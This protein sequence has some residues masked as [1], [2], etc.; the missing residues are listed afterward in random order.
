MVNELDDMAHIHQFVR[1]AS[2]HC[3]RDACGVLLANE[4]SMSGPAI[5]SPMKNQ[6]YNKTLS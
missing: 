2:G 6:S 5:N 3:G 4:P 1:Q